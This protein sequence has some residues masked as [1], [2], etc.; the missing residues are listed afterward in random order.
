MKIRA[1]MYQGPGGMRLIYEPRDAEARSGASP[2]SHYRNDGMGEQYR[3]RH[4]KRTTRHSS[5]ISRTRDL[6]FWSGLDRS[7]HTPLIAHLQETV[8]LDR[9]ASIVPS[10][11][12]LDIQPKPKSSSIRLTVVPPKIC[13]LAWK[14]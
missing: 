14:A 1:C 2:A 8:Q 12:F 10:P 7:V 4:P 13:R 6:A 11:L 9:A 5:K 3:H